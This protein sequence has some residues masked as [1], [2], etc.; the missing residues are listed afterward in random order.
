MVTYNTGFEYEYGLRTFGG[1]LGSSLVDAKIHVAVFLRLRL[2]SCLITGLPPIPSSSVDPTFISPP[3]STPVPPLVFYSQL[4][5]NCPVTPPPNAIIPTSTPILNK[6]SGNYSFASETHRRDSAN[7]CLA[8]ETSNHF[9][10][11]MLPKKLLDDPSRCST[12]S[13]VHG[14]FQGCSGDI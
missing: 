5:R 1:R 10:G 8:Q 14:E 9:L 4:T 2:G 13:G 6:A 3:T 7:Y 12:I 11:A